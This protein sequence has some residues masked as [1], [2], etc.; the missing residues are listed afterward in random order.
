MKVKNCKLKAALICEETDNIEKIAKKLKEKREK[1]I[2]VVSKKNKNKIL[3]V[4]SVTDIVYKVVA[5]AKDSKKTIAKEIMTSPAYSVNIEDSVAKAYFAMI[6]KN[7]FYC[8]VISKGKI[9]GILMLNEAFNHV[10]KTAKTKI[11][12]R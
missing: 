1:Y 2:L 6:A 7:I 10:V 3:G 12:E 4:I 8:P 5:L 11:K 9:V